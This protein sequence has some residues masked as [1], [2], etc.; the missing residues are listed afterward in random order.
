MSLATDDLRLHAPDLP[1]CVVI[2]CDEMPTERLPRSVTL[3]A[4]QPQAHTFAMIIAERN[5]IDFI[6]FLREP[7]ITD[8]PVLADGKFQRR[9]GIA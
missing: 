6:R 8:D 1:K 3:M 5:Y 7:G 9:A 4:C 2:C